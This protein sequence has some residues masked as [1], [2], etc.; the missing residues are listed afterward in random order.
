MSFKDISYQELWLPLF[1]RLKIFRYFLSRALGA[2]LFSGA[3][4]LLQF[5]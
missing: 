2:L 5:W 1:R 3:G 4:T